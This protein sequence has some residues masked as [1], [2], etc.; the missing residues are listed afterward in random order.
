MIKS[1][2][3]SFLQFLTISLIF[4]S[5]LL[6][7]VVSADVSPSKR[8]SYD[9]KSNSFHVSVDETEYGVWYRALPIKTY[10]F[11]LYFYQT[12][13][14]SAAGTG[15]NKPEFGIHTYILAIGMGN[16]KP[17]TRW[18]WE[19][20]LDHP[21]DENAKLVFSRSGNLAL[22]DGN[23]QIVWQTRTNNKGVVDIQLL[24][25]GNLVLL[26]RNGGFVWQS[27][28]H[29]TNTLLIGQG[30]GPGSST[31]NK[32]VNGKYSMVLQ[33]KTLRLFF[34]P[35]PKSLSSKPLTYYKVSP[36]M[37]LAVNITFN[38]IIDP[39]YFDELIMFTGS[40]TDSLFYF[41]NPKFN[42]T[43]SMLRLSSD[44]NLYIYTY[45]E[46]PGNGNNVWVETYAAFSKKERS[47]CFLPD[48]CGSYGL[49]EDHQCVACPTPKGLMGWDK[50]CKLPDV[51]SY[52]ASTAANVGYYKVKDVEDYRPLGDS[53][54]EGPMTVKECMKKCSD[55]SKCVGF[56][57][58]NKG[59][60][61]SLAAQFNTLAKLHA[62]F[63]GLID[64]Y[65]KYKK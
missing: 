17:T 59:S 34:N 9:L 56:F 3:S 35:N 21:V 57:Y 12:N 53:D 58:R 44:G 25:N 4:Y 39:D 15:F 32:I 63:S 27:F 19:A 61:C 62:V 28:Y 47:E 31:T 46:L 29:P 50:K 6:I 52:N 45:L 38:T 42:S 48:K 60:M 30:L 37:D 7:V 40:G 18:V 54:G 20:N 1:Y 33:D 51:P 2:T 49:C 13:D 43:W 10:P 8:F 16:L 36:L 5:S 41:A 26:D 65:I 14:E 22:K 23:G 11:S 55:E 64:A 24:P